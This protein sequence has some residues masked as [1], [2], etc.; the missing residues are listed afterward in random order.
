[1]PSKSAKTLMRSLMLIL[2]AGSMAGCVTHV[3]VK[4]TQK[5]GYR[6]GY[7]AGSLI[8]SNLPPPK[9]ATQAKAKGG[10]LCEVMPVYGWPLKPTRDDAGHLKALSRPVKT[11]LS[12]TQR[13]VSECP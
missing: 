4:G 12:K 10:H 9:A 13:A 1:M 7:A 3:L 8:E 11:T 6:A 2:M 5:I